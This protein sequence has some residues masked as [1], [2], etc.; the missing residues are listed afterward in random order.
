M[1]VIE[2]Q[3]ILLDDL[4]LLQALVERLER[5]RSGRD[6]V[7]KQGSSCAMKVVVVLAAIVYLSLLGW[8]FLSVAKEGLFCTSHVWMQTHLLLQ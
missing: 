1:T 4:L 5:G 2:S 3:L 8:L 7:S 6:T